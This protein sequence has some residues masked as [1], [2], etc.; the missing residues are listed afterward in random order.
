MLSQ[1]DDAVSLGEY[2]SEKL[3]SFGEREMDRLGDMIEELVT[4]LLSE[5]EPLERVAVV[6]AKKDEVAGVSRVSH[7]EHALTPVKLLDEIRRVAGSIDVT[8]VGSPMQRI[9]NFSF[10]VDQESEGLVDTVRPAKPKNLIWG[11]EL[12]R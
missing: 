9:L 3:R 12:R 5:G 2:S 1:S 4:R 10:G 7:V 6:S 8:P 11:V